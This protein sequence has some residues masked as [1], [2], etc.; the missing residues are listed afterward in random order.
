MLNQWGRKMLCCMLIL[1]HVCKSC[2]HV[3]FFLLRPKTIKSCLCISA[4]THGCVS[5]YTYI[6]ISLSISVY[7][8]YSV[9]LGGGHRRCGRN[10]RPNVALIGEANIEQLVSKY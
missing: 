3:F 1:M 2:C 4:H 7:F 9:R 10:Y 5:I 6:L 8:I